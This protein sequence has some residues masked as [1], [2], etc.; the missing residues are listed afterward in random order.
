[1]LVVVVDRLI[2]AFHLARFAEGRAGVG[3]A[4]VLRERG[5]GDFQADRMAFLE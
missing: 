1:M 5:R 2:G 3:V 4:V